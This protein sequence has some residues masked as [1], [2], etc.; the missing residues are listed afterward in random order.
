MSTPWESDPEAGNSP[1]IKQAGTESLPNDGDGGD[2]RRTYFR[3]SIAFPYSDLG[4][5]RR[6]AEVV[7]G[8]Y[9]GQCTIDQLAA[10]LGQSMR[11]GSFR[12]KVSTVQMFGIVDNDRGRLNLTERGR[13]VVDATTRNSALAEAFLAVELY[14]LIFDRHQGG[15]LPRDPGLEAEMVDLGVAPKQA[16]RARQAFQ[17]SAD[18]AGF[19][20]LGRER[21]VAPPQAAAADSMS[22][23]ATQTVSP[24]T[25]ERPRVPRVADLHPLLAGLMQ[26]LPSQG[27]SFPCDKRGDWLNAAQVIFRLVYGKDDGGDSGAGGVRAAASDRDATGSDDPRPES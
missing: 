1:A 11:S 26:E 23:M 17:R 21:L 2:A 3:S 25:S 6:I 24:A 7:H 27:Q 22:T 13:R 18:I 19:F 4:D 8:E 15:V 16:E 9:G 5:A 20:R 14:R 10:S 12:T